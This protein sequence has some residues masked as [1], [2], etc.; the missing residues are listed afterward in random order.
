MIDKSVFENMAQRNTVT[1]E[2][3]SWCTVEWCQPLEQCEL[4]QDNI[5]SGCGWGCHNPPGGA[6]KLRLFFFSAVV[7]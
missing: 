4:C 5:V 2:E 6:I 7:L 3:T 1:E